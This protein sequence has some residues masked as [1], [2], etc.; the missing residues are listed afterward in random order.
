MFERLEIY[1][2]QR[3][4]EQLPHREARRRIA[5]TVPRLNIELNRVFNAQTWN[6]LSSYLASLIKIETLLLVG[7]AIIMSRA[8]ILGELLP[9]I[10]AFVAVFADASRQRGMILLLFKP[11]GFI[12]RIIWQSS[13]HRYCHDR[14]TAAG[15]ELH[16]NT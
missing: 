6:R 7:G 15:T 13:I 10:F 9:F 11:A 5:H 2:Y 12:D 16:K 1:P 3:M 14:N 8:F 4:E